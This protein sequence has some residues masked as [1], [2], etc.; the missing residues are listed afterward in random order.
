MT[1][2]DNKSRDEG[3]VCPVCDRH[4]FVTAEALAEHRV[5]HTEQADTQ[6]LRSTV[7]DEKVDNKDG[8][9]L[10]AHDSDSEAS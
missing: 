4:G 10:R 2:N 3:M 7:I 6:A 1:T 9:A 5:K 8:D